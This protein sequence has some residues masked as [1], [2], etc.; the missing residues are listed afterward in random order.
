MR[1]THLLLYFLFAQLSIQAQTVCDSLSV[2]SV[3]IENN[4]FQISVYN[5]S[6]TFIA[7]PYFT[8]DLDENPY[9]DFIDSL[10]VPT[11]LSV[12]SD[13]N[14]GFT[15]GFYSNVTIA[16]ASSVP[17]NS[18]FSGNLIIQDPNDSTFYCSLPFSFTYGNQIADLETFDQNSIQ[19]YPNPTSGTFKLISSDEALVSI[20]DANGRVIFQE[21]KVDTTTTLQLENDG[22]YTLT[23]KTSKGIFHYK[24]MV[25]H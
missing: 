5:S 22:L 12:P 8:V 24:L 23:F 15:V 2:D 13:A 19:L 4:T 20:S 6:Q 16:G 9:I 1:K 21:L 3:I 18:I 10:T 17:N 7:Y 11:F 25:I 14:N